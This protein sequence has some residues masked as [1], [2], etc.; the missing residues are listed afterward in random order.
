MRLFSKK[1]FYTK[2]QLQGEQFS[3][4]EFTYGSPDVRNY[5]GKTKLTIGKYCSFAAQ[6]AILMGGE[7]R[8]DM[9]T[10]YPFPEIAEHWPETGAISGMTGSK[11][12]IIIGNDVWVGYGAIILSG[13]TIGDGAAIGAG[14]VVTRDVEPYAIM[15]GNPA[16]IIRMRFDRLTVTRLLKLAWW[17]WPEEKVRKNIQ[18]ICSPDIEALLNEHGC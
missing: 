10:T 16:K 6:V 11:G 14:A 5:D 7:H 1:L 13:V 15:G 12:D 3:I 17:D 4:G 9:V 2:D 18:L 8:M